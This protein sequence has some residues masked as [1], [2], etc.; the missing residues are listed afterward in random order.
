MPKNETYNQARLEILNYITVFCVARN[1]G[2]GVLRGGLGD[3]YFYPEDH[4][5]EGDLVAL[6][7]APFSKWYLSWYVGTEYMD[8]FYTHNH[9]LQSIEDQSRCYWSNVSFYALNRK[10]VANHPNWKWS[11]KQYMFKDKWL[12]AC[13]KKR[14]AYM[15]LPTPPI[16]GDDGSVILGTRTRYGLGGMTSKKFLNWRKVTVKDMLDFY[17][18]SVGPD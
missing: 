9:L 8:D 13:R 16:F 5:I 10:V 15:V 18:Q 7:S 17:D 11:D 4:P 12:R 3:D 2:D 6:H 1:Y 14:D